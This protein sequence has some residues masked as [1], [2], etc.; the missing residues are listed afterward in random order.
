MANL[1]LSNAVLGQLANP[2]F[3]KVVGA[4]VG[5]AMLGPEKRKEEEETQTFY[6]QLMKA[7]QE[8]NSSAVGGLLA[9]R[10]AKTENTQMV[11]QGMGMMTAAEKQKS[12]M[13]IDNF[14]DVYANPTASVEDRNKALAQA[15][16]LAYSNTVGMTPQS[17]NAFVSSATARYEGTLNTQA[18]LMVSSNPET[19]IADYTSLY[20]PEQSWRV[21][22]AF[23]SQ[24]ATKNA[25]KNQS[26]NS[27]VASQQ[28]PIAR[29]NN[30]LAQYQNIP[31]SQW[32]MDVVRRLYKE[33]FDIEQEIVNRGGQGNPSQFIGG[34]EKLY[35]EVFE[36]QSNRKQVIA[37]QIDARI[38]NE[39]N[40][41]YG[42]AKESRLFTSDQFV[43]AAR[44]N[45]AYSDWEESDWDALEADIASFQE[46]RANKAEYL[47]N[48]KLAP[49]DEAWLKKYPNYFSDDDEFNSD[50]KTYRAENT[51]NLSRLEA[52][53]RLTAKI[54]GA[55][56]QQRQDRRSDRRVKEQAT[57]FVEAFI[58]AGNPDDPRFD[59]NIP[60]E[61]GFMQGDSVYDVIRRLQLTGDD[62]YDKLITKV[63]NK[64]KDNPQAKMRETVMEAFSE[65][66]IETPGEAAVQERQAVIA[67]QT[68]VMKKGIA[69]RQKQHKEETGEDLSDE[70]AAILIQ[71]DLANVLAADAERMSA[72]ISNIRQ[73]TRSQGRTTGLPE[74]TRGMDPVTG[75]EFI[76]GVGD[77]AGAALR[78]VPGGPPSRRQ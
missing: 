57:D 51:D 52:G 38:E 43:E 31:T 21:R 29:I 7:S 60:V 14:M 9:T 54:R 8:G 26:V 32:D 45:P 3:S 44:K 22:D 35:D 61:G 74:A 15:E 41:L 71:Q 18:K 28:A 48:G 58:G 5:E 69:I 77:V 46:M 42:M 65:L 73:Q 1:R 34:A 40:F 59:P 10:G 66:Y 53:N 67:Q 24:T 55:S 11:L 76:S 20:G 16:A 33:R 13:Q 72:G 56:D 19:A 47:R 2:R 62:R 4:S 63:G 27:F 30:E 70:Q 49:T 78:S 37:S 25:I 36:L 6:Q 23:Q 75:Q 17:F 12:L 68:Q 64:I 50:L 39:R